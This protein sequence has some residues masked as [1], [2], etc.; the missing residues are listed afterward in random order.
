MDAAAAHNSHE[1]INIAQ[2]NGGHIGHTYRAA[3]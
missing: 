1:V 3:Q 2:K